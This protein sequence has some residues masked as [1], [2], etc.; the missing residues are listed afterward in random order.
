M[1]KK[2]S[3]AFRKRYLMTVFH[4]VLKK[5]RYFTYFVRLGEISPLN[6]LEIIC[7]IKFA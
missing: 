7:C 4:K 3:I 2:K 5:Q 6:L 1:H